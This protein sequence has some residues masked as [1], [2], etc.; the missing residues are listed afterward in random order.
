MNTENKMTSVNVFFNVRKNL[1][2]KKGDP[3]P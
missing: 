3:H 2:L 1:Q